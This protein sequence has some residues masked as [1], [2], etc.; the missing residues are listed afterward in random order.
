MK[1]QNRKWS[2]LG[3]RGLASL[4]V[5]VM[6]MGFIMPVYAT[7]DVT[8]PTEPVVTETTAPTVPE[9][10]AATVGDD[11]PGV[12]ENTESSE[13][14]SSETTEPATSETTEPA[15]SETSEPATSETT[16][17]AS[18]ETSDPSVGDDAPGT[19]DKETVPDATV[20]QQNTPAG[21]QIVT[22]PAPDFTAYDRYRIDLAALE[23]E[24]KT[25]EATEE[26]LDEFYDRFYAILNSAQDDWEKDAITNEEMD[27]IHALGY[28]ILLYLKD[29]YG[30]EN[31]EIQVMANSTNL[32][33]LTQVTD[34]GGRSFH[35]ILHRNSYAV[36]DTI[37][38]NTEGN[39]SGYQATTNVNK[40]YYESAAFDGLTGWIFEE[41]ETA[42]EY[43]I[44]SAKTGE[45]MDFRRIEDAKPA[46]LVDEPVATKVY[47]Y[48]APD[49]EKATEVAD[50]EPAYPVRYV[51]AQDRPDGT[52]LVLNQLGGNNVKFN[53]FGG[54]N[55]TTAYHS[56]AGNLFL[57]NEVQK[58]ITAA[59]E[60]IKMSLFDYGPNINGGSNELDFAHSTSYYT[61]ALDGHP[62]A[63]YDLS[64]EGTNTT[65]VTNDNGGGRAPALE[66]QLVDNYPKTIA[67]PQGEKDPKSLSLAYLF[68][69]SK[70][71][72][73]EATYWDNIYP[74]NDTN[75]S[76]NPYRYKM[77]TFPVDNADGSGTGL[78]RMVN[79]YYVYD[80]GVNAAWYN[81][82]TNKFELYDYVVRPPYA[83][84]AN[85]ATGGNFTPFNL[86]HVAGYEDYGT[87]YKSVETKPEGAK[88]AYRMSGTSQVS[89]MNN[90]FGMKLEFDF[91]MPAGGIKDGQRM[92]F[93]FFGDDDVWVYI[94]GVLILDI[95]GTHG[96]QAGYIDFS[97]GAVTNPGP[98]GT[99]GVTSSAMVNRLTAGDP[100]H[101]ATLYSI[102]KAA[103]KSDEWL[104][105]NFQD[106]DGVGGLDT[107]KDWSNHKL[108][109]FYME[110]GGNISYCRLKFNMEPLPDGGA[111]VTKQLT[112]NSVVTAETAGIDYAFKLVSVA[113]DGVTETPVLLDGI[114]DEN[115]RFTLKAGESVA[116]ENL[117]TDNEE[118]AHYGQLYRVYELDD[119]RYH[120]ENVTY[121]GNPDRTV[122]KG[123]VSE[124]DIVKYV[125]FRVRPD[126]HGENIIHSSVFVNELETTDFSVYKKVTGNMGDWSK[127]FNFTATM[128]TKNP[129]DDGT[130]IDFN[131]NDWIG[132]VINFTLHHD[133][134]KTFADIPLGAYVVITEQN[135]N[136]TAK[137]VVDPENHEDAS[138]Y[139]N[140][141][142]DKEVPKVTLTTD[143]T[144][145]NDKACFLNDY[146]VKIDTGIALDSL[147]Y[148]LII[149][150]VV[151]GG[152]VLF[153]RK[154]KPQDD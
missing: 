127:D 124:N 82:A 60:N 98:Y 29:T 114:T 136:Y 96:A 1:K 77:A 120:V 84:Y 28:E 67:T 64:D 62:G 36:M 105:E 85:S 101:P 80:S 14:A 103:G 53:A 131:K 32:E 151:V 69:P 79:G 130:V 128:Y 110:R 146:D 9:T 42:G 76:A 5:A 125:E 20:P 134:T 119:T 93:D 10:T 115:G 86:G 133:E 154:R 6:M 142:A 46:L 37:I 50:Q 19:P 8:E 121:D 81:P 35:I 100:D 143:L 148:I 152:A 92:E 17:P 13:P 30:Y 137:W 94:D 33:G 2:A 25:L 147:P 34:L 145:N 49:P 59:A 97:T 11:A 12:P 21:D 54:Y 44:K 90:W 149:A 57:L 47:A 122:C 88:T 24:A 83:A 112:P 107:F 139:V 108:Q 153:L 95:G 99:D 68:D 3:R 109:F 39:Y 45:Y 63:D 48:D 141:V 104:A 135:E 18:S 71:T 78:F 140:D 61:D 113:E 58:P 52:T 55:C 66:L 7:G 73:D 31:G 74:K 91:N 22:S 132:G 111:R 26:V 23:E 72:I 43:Y 89:D 126:D 144:E 56:D 65:P 40:A 16:V 38:T 150:I 138:Q 27:A 116:F 75:I 118:G 51:L 41:A 15:S 102:M 123:V 117:P 129:A 106:V 87:Y 70:K 4:L